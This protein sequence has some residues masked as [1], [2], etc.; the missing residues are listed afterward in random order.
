MKFKALM[1]SFNILNFRLGRGKCETQTSF[2][3]WNS[4]FKGRVVCRYG[5]FEPSYY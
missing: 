2:F 4:T 1:K 3:P 5:W